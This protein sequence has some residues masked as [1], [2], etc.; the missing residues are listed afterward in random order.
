MMNE[1]YF[2]I[3]ADVFPLTNNPGASPE[4]VVD[5][6]AAVIAELTRLH[7]EATQVYRT[8][9]NV[10]QAIKKLILEAFDDAYLNALSDEVV[11]YENCTSLD[12][13]THL[14]TFYAMI[15]PTE[16]TQNYERINTPYDPNQPIETLFQ[17]IQD[18]RAFA[19]AGGQPYGAAM[20]IN[21]AYT[22]VF[23]TGLYPDACRAWQSRAIAAKTWAQFKI[24]FT[25]AHREFRLTNHTAQKS[26]FH[27]ANMMI[28]QGRYGSMQDNVKAI[29]QLATT[30]ASDRGTVAT[31]TTTN[32]KLATQLEVAH[33][34]ISQLKSEIATLKIKIKPV[35]QGQRP[36]RTT[37]NDSYCWSHGFQVAKSHTSATCNVR[38]SGHQ[39]T[40]TK[41]DTMDGVQWGKE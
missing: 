30:T 22:L 13:L 38:K 19:V 27:S 21:V 18:A 12:L 4:V 16:L 28:E 32:V 5:M 11:G 31:L 14:L 3:A 37:N 36:A 24:Y 39:E 6:T 7:R 23:N 10:D 33:A 17:Q 15:A 9:H 2:A 26:G 1:E 40:A 8:Y 35:W 20:L 29:V 34:L 25:T 41:V